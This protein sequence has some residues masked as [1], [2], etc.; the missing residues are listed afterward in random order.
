[1][2]TNIPRARTWLRAIETLKTTTQVHD[3]ITTFTVQS[4]QYV[5][6]TDPTSRFAEFDIR[7]HHSTEKKNLHERTTKAKLGTKVSIVGELDIYNNNLCVELHSLD[8]LSLNTLKQQQLHNNHPALPLPHH[9]KTD[10]ECTNPFLRIPHPQIP[11]VQL[12][13][14]HTNGTNLTIPPHLLQHNQKNMTTIQ[15]LQEKVIKN[16]KDRKIPKRNR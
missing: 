11:L 8:F 14:I 12:L 13:I 9:L 7:I 4:N 15:S 10:R 5:S 1:M 3:N 2:P 16:R 6:G